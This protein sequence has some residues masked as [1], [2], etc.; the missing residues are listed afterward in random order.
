M[1][2]FSKLQESKLSRTTEHH[3]CIIKQVAL[4]PH[5]GNA[6]LRHQSIPSHYDF[7]PL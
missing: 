5:C 7:D 4:M 3:E 1:I 6:R 2:S